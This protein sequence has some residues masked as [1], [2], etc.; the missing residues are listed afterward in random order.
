VRREAPL[1]NSR[2]RQVGVTGCLHMNWDLIPRPDG[3]ENAGP[4]TLAALARFSDDSID[5]GN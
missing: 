3:R 5:P 4:K 1:C 2:D